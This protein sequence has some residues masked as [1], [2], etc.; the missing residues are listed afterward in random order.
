MS[1]SSIG[2]VEHCKKALAEKWGYV[3]GTWG[4]VL[5][6]T[7]L[8]QKHS[9]YPAQVGKYLDFIKKN[10]LGRRTADCVGLIKSYLWWGGTNPVY[11]PGTDVSADMLYERAKEKGSI[12]QPS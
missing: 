2:L 5:N 8:N 7:L 3:Y 10:W 1:K 12:F 11:Y 9:Q 6:S 4:Q